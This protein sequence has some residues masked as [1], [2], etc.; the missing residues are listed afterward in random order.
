MML[1]IKEGCFGVPADYILVS[2]GWGSKVLIWWKN[3]FY[4][5]GRKFSKKIRSYL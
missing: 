1:E 4:S 5:F 2:S 3:I